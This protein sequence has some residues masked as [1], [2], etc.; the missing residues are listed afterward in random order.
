M[1]P[2]S[3][4]KN[5][6]QLRNAAPSDRIKTRSDKV[7]PVC[8]SCPAPLLCCQASNALVTSAEWHCHSLLT[9]TLSLYTTQY[10]VN[11]LY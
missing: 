7:S 4:L 3:F 11:L 9:D 6:R 5:M 2:D 1:Q 8:C 10:V